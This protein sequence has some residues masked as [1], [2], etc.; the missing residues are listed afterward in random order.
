MSDSMKKFGLEFVLENKSKQAFSQIIDQQKRLEKQ[1]AYLDANPDVGVVGAWVKEFPKN[2][3]W[4]YPAENDDNKLSLVKHCAIAHS[5]SMIRKSVLD[6][7][8]I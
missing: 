4:S 2:K 1:V 5:A 8:Q 7:H 3:I 6:S